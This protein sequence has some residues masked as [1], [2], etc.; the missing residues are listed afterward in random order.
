MSLM[1]RRLCIMQ[2]AILVSF[3]F[4]LS[5]TTPAQPL[6]TSLIIYRFDP[7]AFTEYSQDLQL[8]KEI[9]FSIPPNCGLYDTFPAP[10]GKFLLIELSC[11][12]GQTVLF[13]DVEFGASTQPVTSSDA[14]FLAW[15]PDGK[16]AYLKVDSLGNTQVIRA[17]T[18]GDKDFVPI[19]AWTYDLS[20]KPDSGDFT[21]TFSRGLGQGSELWLATHDG[22]DVQAV[23]C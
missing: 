1:Q 13:L 16:A 15:T 2:Y 18:N 17:Y 20:P 19:T 10:I 12:N 14:H 22:K 11:P 21:F 9:P 8:V 7:P 3:L 6:T 5:C 4:L 23:I